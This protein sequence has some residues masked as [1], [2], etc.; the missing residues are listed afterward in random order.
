MLA[1][2]PRVHQFP[3][4]VPAL[5]AWAHGESERLPEFVATFYGEAT[6]L[7]D[8]LAEAVNAGDAQGVYQAATRLR[9]LLANVGVPQLYATAAALEDLARTTSAPRP[10]W[11]TSSGPSSPGSVRIS[12][13]NPGCGISVGA[14]HNNFCMPLRIRDAANA[15]SSA[16]NPTGSRSM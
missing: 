6:S 8:Q 14:G 2:S 16:F 12:P 9:R 7:H 4:A 15:T 13:G 10:P 1:I 11:W 5:L 3:G